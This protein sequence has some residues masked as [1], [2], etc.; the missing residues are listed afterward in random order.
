MH[1]FNL[2]SRKGSDHRICHCQHF[3]IISIHA[4]AKGATPKI[5]Y[6][7]QIINFYLVNSNKFG[8]CTC[9]YAAILTTI[10]HFLW[11]EP[12][13]HSMFACRS[14]LLEYCFQNTSAV[15]LVLY[16]QCSKSLKYPPHRKKSYCQNALLLSDNYFPSNKSAD[17]LPSH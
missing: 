10:Y 13:C 11:C 9:Y 15:R 14:H 7:F 12:L 5:T 8:H 17:Y 4:P 2:R 3:L 16:Q 1:Y 6:F